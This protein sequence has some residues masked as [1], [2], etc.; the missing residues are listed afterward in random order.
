MKRLDN[1][2]GDK[3]ASPVS[4]PRYK[5]AIVWIGLFFVLITIVLPQIRQ[6]TIGLPVLLGTLAE[7]AIMVLF[8]T[9]VILP[10]L[11][12][13]MRPWPPDKRLF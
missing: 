5:M 11:A 6:L 12:R 8:V 3:A 7:V 10:S 13:L 2:N 1:S 9:Y 4:P